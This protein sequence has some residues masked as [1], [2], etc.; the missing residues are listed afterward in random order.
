MSQ[1]PSS[2]NTPEPELNLFWLKMVYGGTVFLGLT[3]GPIMVFAPR[4]AYKIVGFPER[5][6]EQD[7]LVFGIVGCFWT[8]AAIIS[9]FGL[10]DPLKYLVI[11]MVQ[12]IYKSMWLLCVFLPMWIWGDFPEY[13]WTLAIGNFLFLMLDLKGMPFHYLM[14]GDLTPYHAKSDTNSDSATD[15]IP[16]VVSG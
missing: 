8:A 1:Q 2:T 4:L 3:T 12:M 10:K 15:K 5:L 11:P 16:S 13:G 6:P 9:I 14:T 7:P